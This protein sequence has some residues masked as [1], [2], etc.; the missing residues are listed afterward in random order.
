MSSLLNL[1]A[2]F[3]G[4]CQKVYVPRRIRALATSEDVRNDE[5]VDLGRISLW[6]IV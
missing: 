4:A 3:I 5:T 2:R 6:D 1:E